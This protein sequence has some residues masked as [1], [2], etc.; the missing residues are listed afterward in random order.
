MHILHKVLVRINGYSPIVAGSREDLIDAVR[1]RAES[2]TDEYFQH[3]FDWRETDTAGRWEDAYPANVILSKDNILMFT[4]EL[5]ECLEYQQK[6]MQRHLD[7]ICM[8]SSDI[9][10]LFDM[11]RHSPTNTPN[12]DLRCLSELMSGVYNY[13]SGFYNVE[14]CT[15]RITKHTIEEVISSPGDWAL[16]MFDYHY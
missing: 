4:S 8:V 6:E 5:E 14:E 13:D 11:Y 7:N 10:A 15:A 1:R 2:A 9:K 16:V 12:W 3:A